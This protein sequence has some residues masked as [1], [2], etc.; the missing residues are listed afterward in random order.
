MV[1]FTVFVPVYVGFM[2]KYSWD[3]KSEKERQFEKYK[4]LVNYYAMKRN[5]EQVEKNLKIRKRMIELSIDN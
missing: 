5:Q 3:Y 2:A 1:F 4:D